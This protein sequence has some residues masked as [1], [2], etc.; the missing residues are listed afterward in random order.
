MNKRRT[1]LKATS[2]DYIT[3]LVPGSSKTMRLSN[4]QSVNLAIAFCYYKWCIWTR[5]HLLLDVGIA[6]RHDCCKRILN[7]TGWKSL[8]RGDGK[9]SRWQMDFRN[10]FEK[11]RDLKPHKKM[12]WRVDRDR[13]VKIDWRISWFS[14]SDDTRASRDACFLSGSQSELSARLGF[15]LYALILI[16]L[17]TIIITIL[18]LIIMKYKSIV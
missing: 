6:E 14:V 10:I 5:F 4:H 17:Q 18:L 12:T 3:T 8:S 7:S 15:L 1:T 11:P 16:R 9:T 13:V 2:S